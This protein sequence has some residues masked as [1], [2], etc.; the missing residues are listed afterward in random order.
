MAEKEAKHFIKAN[1]WGEV[2][3]IKAKTSKAGSYVDVTVACMGQANGSVNAFI[4][5][6][7]ERGD[8]FYDE[9]NESD[10]QTFYHFQGVMSQYDTDDGLFTNFVAF[11]WSNMQKG[12]QD[13]RAAFVCLGVVK[14]I[15][16]DYFSLEVT[17]DKDGKPETVLLH[18][19]V[20]N[21][22]D[23]KSIEPGTILKAK[24]Y[25][26]PLNAM[27][28]YGESSGPIRPYVKEIELLET[29]F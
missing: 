18:L 10:G 1:I 24:G 25:L 20:L 21:S 28:E 6:W 5:I 27:D 7:K 9:L 15:K 3:D 8:K 16:G 14:E 4:R 26:R 13:P 12:E 19:W 2:V 23:R 29:P 17:K 11:Q 22:V